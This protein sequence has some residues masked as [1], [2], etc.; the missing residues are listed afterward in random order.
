MLAAVD[1]DAEHDP[2]RRA[3]VEDEIEMRLAAFVAFHDEVS[4]ARGVELPVVGEPTAERPLGE[5]RAQRHVA[6]DRHAAALEVHIGEREAQGEL[7]GGV[8]TPR[9][10]V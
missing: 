5:A 8:R 7:G 6:G 2:T 9:A 10:S 1:L 4:L 3:L